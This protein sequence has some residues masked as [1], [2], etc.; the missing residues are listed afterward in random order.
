MREKIILNHSVLLLCLCI[1]VL[2]MLRIQ[3]GDTGGHMDEYDYLFVGKTLLS[4]GHWP[5]HSYIF[6]WD[7]NWR[8]LAWGDNLFGGLSGARII[9]AILGAL[10]LLGM[11]SF[12]YTLWNN[13]HGVALIAALLL[14]FEGSHLYTSALATY[15]IVSF[16]QPLCL[17]CHVYC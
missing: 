12:V 13:N 11:Y 15:D 4:G 9:A 6:G 8:L 5:T 2:L 17:L 7:L 3:L 14:G 10:S 16:S 1:P